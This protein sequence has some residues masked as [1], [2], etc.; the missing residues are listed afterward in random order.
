MSSC[1]RGARD[2][3]SRPCVLRGLAFPLITRNLPARRSSQM[4][5]GSARLSRGGPL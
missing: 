2:P 5:G 4:G 3:H 1:A